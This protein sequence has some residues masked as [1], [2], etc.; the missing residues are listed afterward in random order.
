VTATQKKLLPLA[1]LLLLSASLPLSGCKDLF[2]S[3][4]EDDSGDYRNQTTNPFLGVWS[5]PYYDGYSSYYITVTISDYYWYFDYGYTAGS[6]TYTR[7]G[8]SADLYVTG[9]YL[10]GT[11][12][13]SGDTLYFNSDDFGSFTLSKVSDW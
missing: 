6:G 8:N 4:E 1:L 12:T 5:G 11:A 10:I 3:P 13:V 9:N 2:H 7:N